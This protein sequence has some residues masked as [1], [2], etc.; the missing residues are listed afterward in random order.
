MP[1]A[2]AIACPARSAAVDPTSAGSQAQEASL[3]A[4]PPPAA[5]V[6]ASEATAA[7]VLHE[8]MRILVRKGLFSPGEAER[9]VP[10]GAGSAAVEEVARYLQVRGRLTPRQL[11]DMTASLANGEPGAGPRAVT[12]VV[13]LLFEKGDLTDGELEALVSP[14]G[15]RRITYVPELARLQIREQLRREI[16][17]QMKTEGW[18]QPSVVPK[19]LQKLRIGGD[20]RVRWEEALF[21]PGNANGG[22]FPDFNAINSGSPVDVKFVDLSGQRYVNV[23]EDRS[24]PRLRLRLALDTE[25]TPGVTANV[26]LASGENGSPV[27]PN[28]TLGASG[29][30]FSKYP[31]WIDRAYLRA[32]TAAKEGDP[33]L[34][35]WAG[36]FENPFLRTELVWSDNVNLDGVAGQGRLDLG[37]GFAAFATA[38]AFPLN[39]TAIAY[40]PE[41]PAKLPSRDKWLFGGQAGGEWRD[42][43][44]VVKLGVAYYD[45]Y[46]VEGRASSPCD[47]NLKTVTCDTDDTRPTW[48]QK[49][50]TYFP[51]RTPSDAALVAESIGPTSRYQYFGL[52]SPFREL[53]GTARLELPAGRLMKLTLDGDAVW[54]AAFSKSAVAVVALN[55][56]QGCGATACGTYVGGGFG[57]LARIG[58]GSPRMDTRWSWSASVAYR[59][60]ESD[61]TL[62]AFT[63]S[64]FGLGGTNLKGVSANAYLV[65]A[66]RVTLGVR[67]FSADEVAGPPYRVDVVQTDVVARF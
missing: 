12:E 52:A 33:G 21:P 37:H 10:P 22:Q 17:D 23:D 59:Y 11:D 35:A 13:R 50:N 18:A 20:V 48:A 56:R 62:D 32:T 60:L 66:E 30:D 29:G 3:A 61:A 54:N 16:L 46:G 1:A 49:G 40:P 19:W 57:Y 28:Q 6:N 67:W 63:D 8:V 47:T 55:N 43:R 9:L 39:I 15:V 26:R 4:P 58:L 27:S 24:R 7:R 51:L 53:V 38:G 44:R 65:L 42:D 34:T 45:Y 31:I 14:D 2:L 5:A 64:D 41:R 36:R 25:V